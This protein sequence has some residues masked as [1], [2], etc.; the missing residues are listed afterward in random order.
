MRRVVIN[1]LENSVQAFTSEDDGS[2]QV[3]AR[4]HV[5]TGLQDGRIEMRFHDNGPGIAQDVMPHIFE[6]LFST[7]NFGVG[8]GMPA[9][10]QI[11]ELHGGDIAVESVAGEGT[12]V[13]LWLPHKE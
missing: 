9:V 3:D 6:P 10:K 13:T 7:K 8:L 12:T 11:M 2:L 5:T 4:I 1:V